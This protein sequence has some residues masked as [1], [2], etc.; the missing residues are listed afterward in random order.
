MWLWPNPIPKY[1][2]LSYVW[3]CDMTVIWLWYECD[4][5]VTWMWYDD[6]MML[7]NDIWLLQCCIHIDI[8]SGGQYL[9]VSYLFPEYIRISNTPRKKQWFGIWPIHFLRSLVGGIPYD[10]DPIIIAGWFT[11]IIYYLTPYNPQSLMG[12]PP[13]SLGCHKSLAMPCLAHDLRLGEIRRESQHCLCLSRPA[14]RQVVPWGR[15][16]HKTY[17]ENGRNRNDGL[18]SWDS[19]I[20]TRDRA[21]LYVNICQLSDGWNATTRLLKK[22]CFQWFE[23]SNSSQYHGIGSEIMFFLRSSYRS[24]TTQVSWPSIRIHQDPPGS[25]GL[26]IQVFF[27]REFT[28][29][30]VI[31]WNETCHWSK[32]PERRSHIDGVNITVSSPFRQQVSSPISMVKVCQSAPP[33]GML[34][35]LGMLPAQAIL[36]TSCLWDLW[37]VSRGGTTVTFRTSTI[38]NKHE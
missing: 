16:H 35:M 30:D 31:L 24:T 9:Q 32:T 28:M 10:I 15:T 34:G 1:D 3:D 20:Y 38:W 14:G 37:H 27:H 8:D 21:R 23:F 12:K 25:T 5:N 2:E 11:H 6:N 17:V 18:S 13:I 36:L 7:Y 33:M 29:E 26:V 22:S 4:M 19:Q